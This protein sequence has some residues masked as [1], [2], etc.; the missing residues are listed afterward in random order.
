[1]AIYTDEKMLHAQAI[2]TTAEEGKGIT[3]LNGSE[4]VRVLELQLQMLTVIF[5]VIAQGMQSK[6]LLK[7]NLSTRW[8]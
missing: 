2:F 7:L 1:L 5:T 3:V 4:I 8:S 6:A